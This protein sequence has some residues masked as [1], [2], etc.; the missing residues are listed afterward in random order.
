MDNIDWINELSVKAS[1]GTTG[2]S[3]IDDYAYFGLIGSGKT[4]NGLGSLGISQASNY[5]LTWER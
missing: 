2:N 1:Y 5:D 3:S 4:Y